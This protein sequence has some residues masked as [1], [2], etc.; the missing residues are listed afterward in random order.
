MSHY[1]CKNCGQRYEYCNCKPLV[2]I[3][4][5]NPPSEVATF[6]RDKMTPVPKHKHVESDFKQIAKD[7]AWMKRFNHNYIPKTKEELNQWEPHEWVLEALQIA[8]N[9][10]MFNNTKKV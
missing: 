7:S 6:I 5:A 8:Y 1:C 4:P 10:G 2:H 3:Q 9:E